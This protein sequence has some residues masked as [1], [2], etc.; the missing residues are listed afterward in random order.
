MKLLDAASLCPSP[1][2]TL[3]VSL[4][5][6][7]PPPPL[8]LSLPSSLYHL[9]HTFPVLPFPPPQVGGQVDLHGLPGSPSTPSWVRLASTAYAKTSSIVVDADV[10]GWPVGATVA[11]AST[12]IDPNEAETAVIAGGEGGVEG[13]RGTLT[14][15]VSE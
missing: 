12:A 2:P 13:G 10:S 14:G 3:I 6:P 4:S 9:L 5:P 8:S 1:S 15:G 11:I 7:F